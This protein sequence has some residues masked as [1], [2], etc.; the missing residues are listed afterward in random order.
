[1][2]SDEEEE[3]NNRLLDNFLESSCRRST[4]THLVVPAA[5]NTAPLLNPSNASILNFPLIIIKQILRYVLTSPSPLIL[6]PDSTITASQGNRTFVEPNVLQVCKVFHNVGLP[7]LYGE[8]TLTTSSPAT[9]FDFDEHLLSLRG[10]KRQMIT[11][12]RLEIDWADE[13]WAKFPLVARALGELKSLQK[14][15]LHIVMIEKEQKKKQTNDGTALMIDK[16]ANLNIE[17]AYGGQKYPSGKNITTTTPL[18]TP[19]IDGRVKR[20]G[21]VV[22]DAMLK[23]E[24]KILKDLVTDLKK[25][26]HFRLLGFRNEG[27]ARCLEEHVRRDSHS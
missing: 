24:M 6:Q 10:S 15:K 23:A 21:P 22:A 8:N 5:N 14:L 25:L 3:M 19:T 12:V 20:E 7:I 1:M 13:L 18:R 17:L 11:S 2:S 26:K 16:D 9:S 27:F 4:P